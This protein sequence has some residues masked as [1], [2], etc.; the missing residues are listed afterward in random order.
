MKWVDRQLASVVSTHRPVV[1]LDPGNLVDD[2]VAAL[3]GTLYTVDD[4]LTLRKAWEQ[5]GRYAQEG[6]TRPVFLVQS[7][8]FT[9]AR[10]L[11]WDIEQRAAVAT[12]RWPIG[13]EWR[14]AASQL[15]PD[16]TDLLVDLARPG[17]DASDVASDLLRV[18]FG[19][20]LPAPDSSAELDAVVH[21]V[22]SHLVPVSLWV[23]VRKLIR[24]PLALALAQPTHDY[25]LLQE[26]WTEWLSVGNKATYAATLTGAR[27]AIASLLASGLLRPVPLAAEDLPNWTTIGA[28]QPGAAERLEILLEQLPDPWPPQSATDWIAVASWWGDVRCAAAGAQPERPELVESAWSR[29]ADVDEAFQP[30]LRKNYSLLFTSSRHHPVTV[31][32]VAPF[33]ARRRS[34]TGRRQL[35]VVLDGLAFAQWSL[36]RRALP[37]DVADATGCFAM[38]PTLTSVS[39]QAILA[40]AIPSAFA[41][42]LWTTSKES[43][44]WRAFWA[45][46]GLLDSEVG[47]HLT[48]GETE[49][50]VP[51]LG[52]AEI[53]AVVVLAVDEIMH[54]SNLLGDAQVSASLEEWTR[55]GF[56]DVLIKRADDEGFEAWVTADHGN[57]EATPSGRVMEGPLVDH[58]GTRVRLYENAVLRDTA[59]PDGI[60]WDPPGLPPG[61]APLFAAGRTG[62]HSGGRKVSHG[63]LSLDEV[64][65]PFA[66][67]VPR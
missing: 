47:Y 40:G 31:N 32:Q 48:F 25:E 15:P 45:N 21:L 37:I 30:W 20:V 29:W 60:E 7:S 62:Y 35:L 22:A 16:L 23:F 11:P 44:R 38:C 64:I 52:T 67:V 63:G 24:G 4:Y 58:A 50:D 53:T 8:E 66:R 51:A 3:L 34:T 1:I 39:R 46:E 55:H 5:E 6:Q 42:S 57:V 19:V 41:D 10:A 43:A 17:R 27:A 28:T 33:L 14:T 56:L 49:A 9:D 61:K 2:A 13:T 59:R 65:V 18:G 26:A 36:L 54:G 12:V